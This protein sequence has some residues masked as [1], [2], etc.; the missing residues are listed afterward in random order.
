MRELMTNH[1]PWLIAILL[2]CFLPEGLTIKILG[3][4]PT[5][6]FF[7]VAF[8]LALLFLVW[9][10]IFGSFLFARDSTLGRLVIAYVLANFVSLLTNLRDPLRSL[11]AMKVIIFGYLAY[12]VARSLIK[13]REDLRFITYSWVFFG[14]AIAALLVYTYSITWSSALQVEN[15]FVV[16]SEVEISMGRS[17]YLAAILLPILPVAMALVFASRGRMAWLWLG[18]S[19]LMTM[20]LLIT[21][22]R[23]AILSLVFGLVSMLPFIQ[24]RR[25]RL[26]WRYALLGAGLIASLVFLIP[27]ELFVTIYK[28]M[29]VLYRNSDWTRLSLW[30]T[31]WNQFLRNPWLGVG[32]NCLYIY[33]AQYAVEGSDSHNY[34][35]N[36]LAEVGIVGAIPFFVILATAV[37]RVYHF[38][39]SAR[40]Q[41]SEHVIAIGFFCGL[42][43]TLVHGLVEPTF[44]G[45]QYIVTF[46]VLVA[47]VSAHNAIPAGLRSRDVASEQSK[48][49]FAPAE[50]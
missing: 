18:I 24:F 49:V 50:T 13:T 25:M 29:E 12:V 8:V 39:S 20:G 27:E 37:K 33:N 42:I 21:M 31:A 5:I 46:W 6:S 9:K 40:L 1:Q 17:N 23:G 2:F 44:T 35:L 11:V 48:R 4:A 36:T 34:V 38:V 43:A 45:Q 19:T 30:A 15:A 7:D 3:R 14:A 41:P 26:N 28:N 16:K 22:S 47:I 32:P 10:F